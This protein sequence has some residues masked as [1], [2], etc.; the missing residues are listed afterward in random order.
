MGGFATKWASAL[1][2][3]TSGAV[4]LLVGIH[5]RSVLGLVAAVVATLLMPATASAGEPIVTIDE[6][7]NM[8]WTA[9]G[10]TNPDGGA[11]LH[12]NFCGDNCSIDNG[13]ET[14]PSQS[15]DHLWDAPA[16]PCSPKMEQEYPYEPIHEG[17]VLCD[18]G[19]PE[20]RTWNCYR[21][22]QGYRMACQT[23]TSFTATGKAGKD[24]LETRTAEGGPELG[25]VN[26]SGGAN[27]DIVELGGYASSLSASG[28]GEVAF[29]TLRP[30]PPI[31][32]ETE[33]PDLTWNVNTQTGVADPSGPATTI[34]F[35]GFEYIDMGSAGAGSPGH[36]L[37][38]NGTEQGLFGNSGEDTIDGFGGDDILNGDSGDDTLS[39]GHGDDLVQGGFGSD[40]LTGGPGV[41]KFVCGPEFDDGIDLVTDNVPGEKLINCDIALGSLLPDSKIRRHGVPSFIGDDIYEA[42]PSYL[43]T[44]V[45]D[46]K[47]DQT[48]TFDLQFEIDGSGA[49]P[50]TIEGCGS[51][52]KFTVKY[53]KKTTNVT[54]KVVNGNY[55]TRSL[56]PAGTA[57]LALKITPKTNAGV[58]NCV[59]SARSGDEIDGV[60]AQL[61][62]TS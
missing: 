29:D 14:W 3:S 9:V 55:V 28:G 34:T 1:F 4:I 11:L 31:D 51:T 47:K 50:L 41:D 21:Y 13:L 58:L 57:N 46:A 27:D 61:T 6:N 16:A 8:T 18:A 33:A 37:I 53:M 54:D 15:V 10:T 5:G 23:I 44:V 7:G 52:R 26:L 24:K 56:E 35:D 39:G 43:Q 36:K 48:R 30:A 49:G 19:G 40:T 62:A 60:L 42:S 17:I 38:G 2:E 45:W 20:Q 12:S 25:A 22:N 32:G 59:V